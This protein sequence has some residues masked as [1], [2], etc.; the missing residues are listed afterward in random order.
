M[1]TDITD[2]RKH[3][4]QRVILEAAVKNIAEAVLIISKPCEKNHSMYRVVY[5]N[6]AFLKMT[7]FSLEE[8]KHNNPINLLRGLSLIM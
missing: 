5:S 6:D 8:V 1:E 7:G 3:D 4:N 2:R